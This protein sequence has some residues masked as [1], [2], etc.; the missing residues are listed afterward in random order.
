MISAENQY[1]NAFC[2]IAILKEQLDC[3][4]NTKYSTTIFY[5]TRRR[6]VPR[7]KLVVMMM[8]IE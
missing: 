7:S 2:A 4:L 1:S 5:C 3:V 6:V 8:I